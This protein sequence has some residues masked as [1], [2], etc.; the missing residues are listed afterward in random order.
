MVKVIH[1]QDYQNIDLALKP[2]YSQ[3]TKTFQ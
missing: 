3:K 2:K 1:K